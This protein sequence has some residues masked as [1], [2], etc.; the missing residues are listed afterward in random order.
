MLIMDLNKY[1]IVVYSE[2]I[3]YWVKRGIKILKVHRVLEFTV[4]DFMSEYRGKLLRLRTRASKNNDEI[5][6]KTFKNMAN[7]LVGRL[8]CSSVNQ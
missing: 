2:M 1:G 3:A 6:Y 4:E 8:Q 5:M 7:G